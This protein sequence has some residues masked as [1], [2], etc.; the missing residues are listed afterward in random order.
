MNKEELH[1]LKILEQQEELEQDD[2][3]EWQELDREIVEAIEEA[4]ENNWGC[5]VDKITFDNWRYPVLALDVNDYIKK[6]LK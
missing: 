5:K 4:A 1:R 3:L 2:F 6:G